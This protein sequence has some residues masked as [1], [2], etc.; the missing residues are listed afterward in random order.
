MYVRGCQG[1]C[2]KFLSPTAS[3]SGPSYLRASFKKKREM[4]RLAFDFYIRISY[5]SISLTAI[6]SGQIDI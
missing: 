5:I 1:F 3:I 4:F 6:V 2:A